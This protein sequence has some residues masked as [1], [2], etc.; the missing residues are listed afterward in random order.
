MNKQTIMGAVVVA[1]AC[2]LLIVVVA[3]N[4]KGGMSAKP[5]VYPAHVKLVF[6]NGDPVRHTF[7]NFTPTAPNNTGWTCQAFTKADGSFE[8]RS[9]FSNDHD[10]AVPGEYLCSLEQGVPAKFSNGERHNPSV[11]PKK[12]LDSK[13]SGI[14]VV[15]KPEDNDLGTI[16]LD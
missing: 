8:I 15:I 13:T 2:G 12:Y 9:N 7:V 14:T 11:I 4:W 3:S 1:V 6:K 16:K 10:G 5:A